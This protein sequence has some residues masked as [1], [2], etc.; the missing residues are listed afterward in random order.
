MEHDVAGD[1]DDDDDG[2]DDDDDD[3]DDGDDDGGDNGDDD[4]QQRADPDSN[5]ALWKSPAAFCDFNLK[6]FQPKKKG[7]DY[8]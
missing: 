4:H 2:D 8:L 3:D 1:D 6:H 7:E 5:T